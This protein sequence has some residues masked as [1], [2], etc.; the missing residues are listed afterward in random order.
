V[1]DETLTLKGIDI[2]TLVVPLKILVLKC[3]LNL[4]SLCIVR[5]DYPIGNTFILEVPRKKHNCVDFF[6]VLKPA[7]KR[8]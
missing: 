8:D 6:L 7:S 2:E 1:T 5:G 4:V 3:V